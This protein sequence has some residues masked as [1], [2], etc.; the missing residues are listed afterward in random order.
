MSLFRVKVTIVALRC[1]CSF[2]QLPE[3][4]RVA[5]RSCSLSVWVDIHLSFFR[6]WTENDVRWW[7]QSFSTFALREVKM[8]CMTIPL[9]AYFFLSVSLPS[10]VSHSYSISLMLPSSSKSDT[11]HLHISLPLSSHFL[12]Y[13][14]FLSA[15]LAEGKLF[16]PPHVPHFS[17]IVCLLTTRSLLGSML[18]NSSSPFIFPSP[19]SYPRPPLQSPSAQMCGWWCSSCCC[20]CQQWLCLCL[21]TSALWATTA[22]WLMAKVRGPRSTLTN[23]GMRPAVDLTC[24]TIQMWISAYSLSL[25]C[26][27]LL[28]LKLI[29]QQMGGR[30]KIIAGTLTSSVCVKSNIFIKYI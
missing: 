29:E 14:F 12:F 30:R 7:K 3:R 16:L 20:W 5:Y 21:S 23:T 22:V 9:T 1:K 19:L 26:L 11:L 18:F 15:P 6:S 4:L 24:F 28:W 13:F 25:C 8:N 27:L 10:Y 17:S 2:H